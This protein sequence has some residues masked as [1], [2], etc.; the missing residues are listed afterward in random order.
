MRENT[1]MEK[2]KTIAIKGGGLKE[3]VEYSKEE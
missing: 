3:E 1:Q 2:V